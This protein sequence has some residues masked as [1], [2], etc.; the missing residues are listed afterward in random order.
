MRHFIQIVFQNNQQQAQL[1]LETYNQVCCISGSVR[2]LAR[3]GIL[4][5]QPPKYLENYC[6]IVTNLMRK[7]GLYEDSQ[8]FAKQI[9]FPTKSGV[10]GVML[11]II[12]NQGVIVCV[13][14]PLDP[15]GNSIGGR[16]FLEQIAQIC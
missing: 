1:A 11:S 12:P 7:C 14:P 3:L 9:G 5:I 2:D 8:E 6:Q 15:K 13:S 4:L 16:Y 10:S